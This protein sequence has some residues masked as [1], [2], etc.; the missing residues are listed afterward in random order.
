M[1]AL[2]VDT[3]L[4]YLEA[5]PRF[6]KLLGP[7]SSQNAW[8]VTTLVSHQDE[9]SYAGPECITAFLNMGHFGNRACKL[10]P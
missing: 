8:K 2:D 4:S 9:A 3:V 10:A 5:N 1:Q 6:V 7:R